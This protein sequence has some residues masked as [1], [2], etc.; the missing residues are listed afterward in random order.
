LMRYFEQK[1]F[2][3]VK[4]ISGLKEAIFSGNTIFH[5]KLFR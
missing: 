2:V 3:P 5:C 1:I 4:T